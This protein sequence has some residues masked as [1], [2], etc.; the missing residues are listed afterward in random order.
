MSGIKTLI[1]T[2]SEDETAVFARQ[3][4]RTLSKGDVI[5][6]YG[7]LGTGKSVFSRA[8]IR[9]LMGADIDVPSPTFTLVQTYDAALSSLWH[10]DL[11]R[12]EDASEAYEI[13]WEEAISDGIAIIEWPERITALLPQKRYDIFININDD[14]SRTISVKTLPESTNE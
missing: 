1:Q 14:N 4:G 6:L 12:L 13:G 11:Y 9:G 2:K 8:L 7:A 3:F 5:C 10:F